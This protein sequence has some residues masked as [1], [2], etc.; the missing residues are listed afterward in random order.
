MISKTRK[1]RQTFTPNQKLEYAKLMVEESYTHRQVMVYR[2][3]APL[4]S[5]TEN[6]NFLPNNAMKPWLGRQRL[7][8]INDAFRNWNIS[9]HRQ[10]WMLLYLKKPPSFSF[11]TIQQ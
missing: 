7:T 8:L 9:L 2:V 6:N 5:P 4:P 1:V 11:E 3:K 10:D